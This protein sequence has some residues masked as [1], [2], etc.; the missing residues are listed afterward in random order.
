MNLQID[1]I[2]LADEA[3]DLF[4]EK[5]LSKLEP[6]LEKMIE[7]NKKS[8]LVSLGEGCEYIGVSRSTFTSHFIQKGLPVYKVRKVKRVSKREIDEFVKKHE[9]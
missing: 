8:D 1:S 6:T 7:E 5:V 3:T 4:I 2:A 9:Y